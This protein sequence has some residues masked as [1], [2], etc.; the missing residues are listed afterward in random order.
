MMA[1]ES[2]GKSGSSLEVMIPVEEAGAVSGVLTVPGKTVKNGL[3]LAHGAGNDM[4]QPMIVFLAEKLAQAGYLTL[5]FNFL[6]KQEG[7]TAPD[8]PEKLY[9]AWKAAHHF[10]RE[11][12]R[13]PPAPII[14]AGKSMGGRIVSQMVAE[15]QL[16]AGRLIFLG[17]PLHPPGRKERLR[18]RH[19]SAIRIPM[20]FFAGTR[21][22]LCDLELLR[23]VLSHLDA[24]WQLEV[25]EG[26]DHSFK[27]PKTAG[28]SP[29][30]IYQRITEKILQQLA[31]P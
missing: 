12:P 24:P 25:I 5:R 8:R 15:G 30:E 23:K 1:L 29:D 11:H 3:I 21:D 27:V 28:I 17:Y 26:A 4:H 2:G 10:L 20:H 31:G 13:C 7:K 22:P 19:L 6:Y 9:Q 18:D 16:E 14:A